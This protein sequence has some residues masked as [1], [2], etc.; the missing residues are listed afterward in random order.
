MQQTPQMHLNTSPTS[1]E[2]S[3]TGEHEN[4]HKTSK[5]LTLF[6]EIADL[7]GG[8]F[9]ENVFPPKGAQKDSQ[10]CGVWGGLGLG[11]IYIYI[12]IYMYIFHITYLYIYIFPILHMYISYYIYIYNFFRK[13]VRSTGIS[14][15]IFMQGVNSHCAPPCRRQSPVKTASTAASQPATQA[16]RTKYIYIYWWRT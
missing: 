4:E 13:I 5:K 6:P 9:F 7:L 10:K 8:D 14:C 11:L 3:G 1:F 12:Y 15:I 2:G 16:A